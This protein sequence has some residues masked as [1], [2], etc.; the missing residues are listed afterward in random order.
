MNTKQQVLSRCK[1]VVESGGKCPESGVHVRCFEF[2]N[3]E[4]DYYE[5]SFDGGVCT[6]NADGSGDRFDAAARWLKLDNPWR[7]TSEELPEAGEWVLAH[8]DSAQRPII[9]CYYSPKEWYGNSHSYNPPTY[10]MPFPELPK[11]PE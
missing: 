6:I 4:W 2:C 9:I 1:A 5:L 11:A 3:G 7:L 8:Y 10:W